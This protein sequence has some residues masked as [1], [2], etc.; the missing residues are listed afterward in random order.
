[1]PP[2]KAV[3]R[4]LL[5]LLCGLPLAGCLQ[6]AYTVGGKQIAAEV[7]KGGKP[8]SWYAYLPDRAP[9]FCLITR[10][11]VRW[12]DPQMRLG[13]WRARHTRPPYR[14][15]MEARNDTLIIHRRYIWDGRTWG[16]TRPAD[17]LPTLLHDALYQALQAGAPFPR[18]EADAAYRRA[19]R[20]V[21][22]RHGSG[23]Y[24]AIR[25]FGGLF[26]RF[27]NAEGLAIEPLPPEAPLAPLEP[28][29]PE[30]LA[31]EEEAPVEPTK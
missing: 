14:V 17:L 10:R 27:G 11:A 5:P 22:A 16:C 20:R 26:N 12:H 21:A 24:A 18:Q 23:E 8:A 1:M 9:G 13:C 2:V 28:Y 15:L 4:A 30:P 31:G 3:L 19:C 29:R 7:Q 25:L 6:V